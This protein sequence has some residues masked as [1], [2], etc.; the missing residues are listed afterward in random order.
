MIVLKAP[1]GKELLIVYTKVLNISCYQS[2]MNDIKQYLDN[3]E[4]M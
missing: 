1:E 3:V 2:L 4:N